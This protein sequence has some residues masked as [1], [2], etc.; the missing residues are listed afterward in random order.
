MG[1]IKDLTGQKFGHLTIIKELGGG[2]VLCQCDCENHTIKE[3]FKS[4]VVRG[5]IKSCGCCFRASK[6][7]AIKEDLTGKK[8][9]H[10]TVLEELGKSKILCQ[11]DCKNKTQKILYKKA[12]KNGK[13]KS[14]G[15]AAKEY[16]DLTGKQF[17]E[18]TVLEYVGNEKWLCQCSCK[19]KTQRILYR[20][21]L[22]NGDSRSCGCKQAE[23]MKATMIKLY[24]ET[25]SRKVDAPRETWQIDAV[26]SK[27]NMYKYIKSL[28]S[29]PT[30]RELSNNLGITISTTLVKIHNYELNE[31]VDL[32]PMVSTDEKELLSYVKQ[33][34]N[35]EIITNSRNILD[36][37]YELDIYIPDKKIA[38]EFNGNYWHSDLNKDRN[39]HK[40]KTKACKEKGIY[41]IH[42]FEYEWIENKE[43]I[44]GYLSN[45]LQDTMHTK[46]YGRNTRV[47][48]IHDNDIIKDFENYNHL[49]KY[50]RASITIGLYSEDNELLGIMSFGTPRFNKKYQ[51]ELIRLCFKHNIN[52]VGG[53]EKLFNYFINNYKP[54]SII[55]YCNASKFNGEVYTRLGFSSNDW[56]EPN[57]VWC[58]SYN[59]VLPRYQTQK[60]KL[61]ANGLGTN[62]QTEDEILKALGYYK[63]YDSGNIIYIWNN[64]IEG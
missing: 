54:E 1:K 2:K 35:G 12:V 39:Y 14:C 25:N 60:G 53:S 10:W 62:D 31:Y 24:G 23:H 42:I 61:V 7:T 56:T 63:V 40:N 44:K 59:D 13:T 22:I 38:I 36:N 9:H 32:Q 4:N 46:I 21:S 18:W 15:C 48:E 43:G 26:A 19:N 50:C 55:S 30:V 27:E 33:I 28:G 49:Q 16:M 45:I 51:C 8:F 64:N 47:V 29:K 52:V 3:E 41:L 37:N 58:N 17:G 5:T 57:Y 20:S 11:C 34:Y 6:N